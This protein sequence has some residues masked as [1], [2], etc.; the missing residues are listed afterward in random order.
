MAFPIS[1]SI[2]QQHG[3]WEWNGTGWYQFTVEETV[4]SG[5]SWSGITLVDALA[6]FDSIVGWSGITYV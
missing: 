3:K 4:G 6:T 1:P 5:L 2:G